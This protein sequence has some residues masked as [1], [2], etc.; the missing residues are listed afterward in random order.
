MQVNDSIFLSIDSLVELECSEFLSGQCA[1]IT[2]AVETKRVCR[3]KQI[4]RK[5]CLT[6]FQKR[7]AM[8]RQKRLE[9]HHECLPFLPSPLFNRNL[10]S[11]NRPSL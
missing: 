4:R 2:A 3:E 6:S 1:R 5:K 8:I 7:D 11:S 9:F 10:H